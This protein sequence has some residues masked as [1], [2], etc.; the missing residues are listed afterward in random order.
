MKTNPRLKSFLLSSIVLLILFGM[1]VCS[2][3]NA[4]ADSVTISRSVLSGAELRETIQ[5][6]QAEYKTKYDIAYQQVMK[7][8]ADRIADPESVQSKF[9]AYA[10]SFEG[11]PYWYG[12]STTRGFDCS[13]FVRHVLANQLGIDVRHSASSIMALGPRI[14]QANILPG[15]LVGWGRGRYFHHVGIYVGDGKVIDALNPRRDTY[16]RELSTLNS[17]LGKPTFVRV[18]E[19]DRVFDAHKQTLVQMEKNSSF[20]YLSIG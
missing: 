12:G 3:P 6:A 15:D 11:T 16:V 19:A 5:S 4:V 1:G 8:E 20:F 17:W 18:I 7:A 2:S 14:D 13:G 10:V 9:V